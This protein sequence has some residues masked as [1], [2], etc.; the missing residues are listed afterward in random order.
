MGGAS[1]QITFV[2]A[3]APLQWNRSLSIANLTYNLYTYS[4]PLGQDVSLAT[5]LQGL[6]D[7]NVSFYRFYSIYSVF[8]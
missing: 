1:T 5:L 8:L 6:I 4:Y 2:P 7:D 3:T